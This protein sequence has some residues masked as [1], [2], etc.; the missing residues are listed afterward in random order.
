MERLKDSFDRLSHSSS[1][2]DPRLQP[3]Y[4][5]P[6]VPPRPTSSHRQPTSSPS[7]RN[8]TLFEA[9]EWY[10]PS[11]TPKTSTHWARL[12]RALPSLAAIGIDTFW[13]P[14]ASKAGWHG[15]NGYDVY[16][17]YDLGEF[18][19]KDGVATKWGTRRELEGLIEAGRRAGVGM[20]WDVVFNHKAGA[21]Y[22]ETVEGVRIDPKAGV[23]EA[24]DREPCEQLADLKYTQTDRKKEISKSGEIETWT[25]FNFPGRKGK[26]STFRWNW[27]HFNGTDYNHK[28]KE[29]GIWRLT[30]PG[31]KGWAKDVF[32]EP[33]L[34]NYDFL[35][36][37]NIDHLNPEVRAELC[38]WGDWLASQFPLAGIRFDAIKHYSENFLRY[39]INH[40]DQGP[41]RNWFLV[42]EY[43]WADQTVL[44]GVVDRFGGR[45]KLFDVPLVENLSNMSMAK[46]GDL[47]DI[48]KGTLAEVR[49]ECAVTFVQNHDTAS[50]RVRPWFIPHAY[51]LILLHHLSHQPCVFYGDLYGTCGPPPANAPHPPPPSANFTQTF[52]PPCMGGSR[53]HRLT[54]ARKLYA[55]GPQHDFF[56]SPTCVGWTRMGFDRGGNGCAVVLNAGWGYAW[57]RMYVGRERVGERWTDMM[58][59]SWGEVLIDEGGWGVFPCPARAIGVWTSREA[60]GREWVDGFEFDDDIYGL[61]EEGSSKRR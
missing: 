48:W 26:H 42:G 16:D 1:S 9:F 5:A 39:F 4:S 19:Q 51:A 54:L 7:Q 22:S 35:M 23:R 2:A 45:L 38:H 6:P 12:T 10:I 27:S 36:F 25:G 47:R 14:P 56:D 29:N 31:K 61:N 11:P 55:Y 46:K 21:D 44:K 50:S 13:L 33:G 30:G 28:T 15:S 53:L 52:N 18:D 24:Q 17:L 43:W 57:K 40:M 58:G 59:W 32:D 60:S 3:T 49:P 8:H 41:G 34:G 37:S 20:L